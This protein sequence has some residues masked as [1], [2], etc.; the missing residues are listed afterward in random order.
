MK[1]NT[2]L[3]TL[4]GTVGAIVFTVVYAI[5]MSVVS[6]LSFSVRFGDEVVFALLGNTTSFIIAAFVIFEIVF[7][8][9]LFTS[10][11]KEK[12]DKQDGKLI[13]GKTIEK[14]DTKLTLTKAT[15]ISGLAAIII[16]VGMIVVNANFYTE[17][18]KDSIK[19]K[20]FVTTNEYTWDDV[21]RYSLSYDESDMLKFT[22]Q[23][24]DGKAF[25]ILSSSNSCSDK[26]FEEFGDMLSYAGYLADRLDSG[27]RKVQKDIVGL[28]Y[29]E[30]HFKESDDPKAQEAWVKI[31]RIIE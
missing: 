29:M 13:G 3:L 5:I 24:N 12:S 28:E 1:K 9:W 25:Q 16:L 14:K 31:N 15:K 4:I 20:A 11:A 19:Q 8:V 27:E 17:V 6:R 10:M 7:F 21:Y 22:V 18:S 23:M 2:V 26:F 30:Q